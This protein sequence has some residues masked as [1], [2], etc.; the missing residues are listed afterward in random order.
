MVGVLQ[1][2]IV[3][4][5]EGEYPAESIF[6]VARTA[7]GDAL[8]TTKLNLRYETLGAAQYRVSPLSHHDG[9]RE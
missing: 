9:E 1:G 2:S 7:A 5:V 3:Y 6:D 8:V 4:T